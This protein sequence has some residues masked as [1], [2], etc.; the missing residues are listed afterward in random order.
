VRRLKNPDSTSA[1]YRQ[2]VERVIRTYK[3]RYN[4]THGFKSMDGAL[5]FNLLF[6]IWFNFMRPHEALENQVPIQLPDASYQEAWSRLI[7]K[8]L[9]KSFKFL[10]ANYALLLVIFN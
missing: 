1:L 8:A 9:Y 6:G 7:E 4:R 5:V 3:Q 10:W 2:G